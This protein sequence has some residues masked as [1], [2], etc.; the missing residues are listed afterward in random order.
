M[1]ELAV[2]VRLAGLWMCSSRLVWM[3]RPE[4]WKN[5]YMVGSRDDAIEKVC[6]PIDAVD[7]YAAGMTLDVHSLASSRCKPL[8]G[9]SRC[10]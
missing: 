1:K 3:K 9:G 8:P 7:L 6:S 10:V 4:I 5:G 2:F